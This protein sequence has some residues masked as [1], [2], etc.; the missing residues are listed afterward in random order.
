MLVPDLIN[1]SFELLGGFFI[2]NH[3]RV[4]YKTKFVAGVSILSTVFFFLWGVWNIYYYP[5]LGQWL[6]FFGGIFIVI[7][8]FVWI[9]MMIFYNKNSSRRK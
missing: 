7:G 1:A 9:S 3:C 6:S 2:L 4:L 8:N 5:H